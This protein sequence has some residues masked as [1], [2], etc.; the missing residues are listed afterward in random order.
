MALLLR[1]YEYFCYM[2]IEELR[3]QKQ[4]QPRVQWLSWLRFYVYEEENTF[5]T[6]FLIDIFTRNII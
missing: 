6:N 1:W 3:K 5:I 2:F 4:H